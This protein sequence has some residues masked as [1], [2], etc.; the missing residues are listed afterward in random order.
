M[1][2]AP[3]FSKTA[4]ES[5]LM[6][7]F[8]P[9]L[10][11]VSLMLCCGNASSNESPVA[12]G[13]NGCQAV[14]G[15]SSCG[16][17]PDNGT[18]P[19]GI[20]PRNGI[21]NPVNVMTG[22][23]FQKEQ[24]FSLP[25]SSLSFNRM[26]NSGS[27]D[28]NVGLGQGW[29]HSYAVSLY[30]GGN[31][32]REIVQ[33]NGS[34]VSFYPDGTDE[35]G[36]PLMRGSA[37]NHGYVVQTEAHHEWHLPD[38]RVLVF[39]GS[40]LVRIDWP[41]QRQLKMFYRAGRL[42]SVTDETGRVLRL[43]YNAGV[44]KL[45]GFDV[46]RHI[47]LAGHLS[48][49]TLPDGS[50]LEYDYDQNRNLTRVL[51]PDGSRREYHY[52]NE[53]YPHHLT[54]L[55]DRTGVRF[56]SWSYDDYGRAISSE[57]AD[58][59]EKVTLAYPH[60]K[61]VADGEV[62]QTIVTNSLGYESQYTWQ[63]PRGDRYPGLLESA[64]AGCATCAETGF[65]YIYDDQGR[66][67]SAMKTGLGNAVGTDGLSYRYDEQGR[68][69]EIRRIDEFGDDEL[70]ERREFADAQSLLPVRTYLPSVNPT[71]ERVI[72]IERGNR[73][74]PLRVV[75]RGWEPS[76]IDLTDTN[77]FTPI[78]RTTT[79]TYQENQLSTVDGP[80]TDV[81]DITRFQYDSL[82]R[83]LRIELPSNEIISINEYDG[84]GRA[85]EFQRANHPRVTLQY[86]DNGNV[87]RVTRLGQSVQYTYNAE[88]SLVSVT[89]PNGKTSTLSYDE[90]QRLSRVSDDLERTV[91]LSFNNESQLN[92]RTYQGING[93]L[94]RSLNYVFDVEGRIQSINEE[95]QDDTTGNLLS[96]SVDLSYDVSGQLTAASDSQTG[97]TR[98]FVFN[99]LG[100][101][102]ESIESNGLPVSLEY[103]IHNRLIAQT[104]ERQNTTQYH[105]DD[106]GQVHYLVSPDTGITQY[107]YDAAGNRTQKRNAL[108]EVT[109]YRWDAANRLVEQ[110]DIDGTAAYV[111]DSTNGQLIEASNAFS[112]EKYTYTTLAQLKTHTREIDGQRFT[113]EYVY[114]SNGKL[115]NKILPDGQSLR[116]HY[117]EAGPNKDTLRAITK[118][119][120]FGLSQS[121][122]LGEIDLDWRDGQTSYLSHNG[123]RSETNYHADGNVGSMSVTNTLSLEYDYDEYGKIVGINQDGNAQR[124]GYRAGQLSEASTINGDYRYQYD[125]TGNRTSASAQTTNDYQI[126]TLDYPGVAGGNR[127]QSWTDQQTG[128]EITYSYNDAGSP[129][130]IGNLSYTYNANQRPVEVRRDG[131]LIAQYR[132][133]NFGERIKKVT[134]SQNQ[135]KVTY[136]LYDNRT[137]VAEIDGD[138]LEHRQTVYLKHTPVVHLI[139]NDVFAVHSDHL[140][141]PKLLTNSDGQVVW[142]ASHTPL[143][144]AIVN[145]QDIEFNL[146]FP[147]QYADAETG[148]HYNYLR[149]YDPRTGRYLTS[150][151]V[152]LQGGDNTYAYAS[153]DVLGAIDVLGLSSQFIALAGGESAGGNVLNNVASEPFSLSSANSAVTNPSVLT[154]DVTD[155]DVTDTDNL[156]TDYFALGSP[157]TSETGMEN[158]AEQIE[159]IVGGT[160]DSFL[161]MGNLLVADQID[162]VLD[163]PESY[164]RYE[165]EYASVQL[166]IFAE[167]GDSSILLIPECL[168][169]EEIG[170]IVRGV[171]GTLV[172]DSEIEGIIASMA[173]AEDGCNQASIID[174]TDLH[175]EILERFQVAL[176]ADPRVVGAERE[177]ILA[178]FALDEF[179]AIHPDL[180]CGLEG[181][182]ADTS[183]VCIELSVYTAAVERAAS[184]L[185]E[186]LSDVY[187]EQVANGLMPPYDSEVEAA[188][189][190]ERVMLGIVGLFIPLT[191]TDVAIEAATLGFGRVVRLFDGAVDLFRTISRANRAGVDEFVAEGSEAARRADAIKLRAYSEYDVL[192]TMSVEDIYRIENRAGAENLQ[193]LEADFANA[194]DFTAA[195]QDNPRLLEGWRGLE[196]TSFSTDPDWLDS[197]DA[198]YTNNLLDQAGGASNAEL[199]AIHKY[200][201][202]ND[203]LTAGAYGN[204]LT[205]QQQEWMD[206]VDSGLDNMRPTN[207][208]QG[209]V[210][211]GTNRP[212]SEI[213]DRYVNA[214]N[215]GIANGTTPTVTEA[216]I[217]STST[218]DGVAEDFINRYSR[219]DRVEVMFEINT[220]NGVDIDNYSNYGENLNP[221]GDVEL[222][223]L[224]PSGQDYEITGIT[225]TVNP[226]GT[227]RYLIQLSD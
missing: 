131:T 74:L 122:L 191:A 84:Q 37:M 205:P 149:D 30:D 209:T 183:T 225:R 197:Y 142:E 137:L 178:Q 169:E 177:L 176:A 159:R 16:I 187:D 128:D 101:L 76:G 172:H 45:R 55:T 106:F 130:A 48:R 140:G 35:E 96:K 113:T 77:T 28:I 126:S 189:V 75:E 90:A 216:P 135:R 157:C 68:L 134:Y 97:V 19:E 7:R 62:V 194:P 117:Y 69:A 145:R 208:H 1:F 91:S 105:R 201:V 123:R 174:V 39:Q 78:E 24:D 40:Y 5:T 51:F 81:D 18:A 67:L 92:K 129:V 9:L 163:N 58:G 57:H 63:H 198:L 13:D 120:L 171:L 207:G 180:I 41:D 182:D 147:G 133:N 127:L 33:S 80:R 166:E 79:L 179:L 138:T 26:Y 217:L 151:P 184:H 152:G 27:S 89:N 88:N 136:Y 170:D 73:G 215:E 110:Q 116:Y 82:G 11:L 14:E 66:L 219:P 223:V 102:L 95:K 29:Y 61:E 71:G 165:V 139:G 153:N 10:L 34:R 227:I 52:E 173:V 155:L 181:I 64:G 193:R 167:S 203:E 50:F 206:L 60:P 36:Q 158:F 87:S 143:G 125:V 150:D 23:K 118:E 70:V 17:A 218:S 226:D 146:R 124:F 38:S 220:T 109:R 4:N 99:N 156:I 100:R 154:P 112:T 213:I 49:V 85:V 224:L 43:D 185:A 94:I 98:N 59:V 72:E 25:G 144:Q 46:Q 168:D 188:A 210:Y 32:T 2:R 121:T 141:T 132:Y 15:V 202:D 190:R 22:N 199:A 186:T 47:D 3:L 161:N 111:Y 54:G 162:W 222:E 12:G 214:Y 65:E 83:V 103:D 148:T 114:A 108:G 44:S 164:E 93:E 115:Q 221:G 195:V 175:A 21:G 196:D 104:D 20:L 6:S 211:R 107:D 192:S 8:S 160:Y 42:H 86:D 200:T 31:G 212:E 56:A 204:N 53:T 119:S